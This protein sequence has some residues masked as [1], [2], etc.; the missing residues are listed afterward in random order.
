MLLL[1][2]WFTG[3]LSLSLFTFSGN[4]DDPRPPEEADVIAEMT[5]SQ[6][7]DT[8]VLDIDPTA[9]DLL[10][11]LFL[12]DLTPEEELNKLGGVASTMLPS[13]L[14]V[15]PEP[16]VTSNAST[17]LSSLAVVPQLPSPDPL[18][19]SNQSAVSSETFSPA[20][21]SDVQ[22][23]GGSALGD[24]VISTITSSASPLECTLTNG[25]N[26]PLDIPFLTE[27]TDLS[28][29][30]QDPTVLNTMLTSIAISTPSTIVNSTTSLSS[31]VLSD[32]SLSPCLGDSNTSVFVDVTNAHAHDLEIF[33]LATSNVPAFA[34]AEVENLDIDFSAF[35]VDTDTIT[36][37]PD[38]PDECLSITLTQAQH[39]SSPSSTAAED[40]LNQANISDSDD[41]FVESS[42]SP[43]PSEQLSEQDNSSTT[44]AS[45][46]RTASDM[47]LDTSADPPA[48]KKTK[49]TRR[50]KN[51]VASQISRAKRKA[52]NTSMFDRVG[53]LE[54]ENDILRIQEKELTAEIEKLKKLLVE[55][56]SQ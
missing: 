46:K 12:S 27:S 26:D 53:E 44:V 30:L 6:L 1:C 15:D 49:L 11:Q 34:T 17:P 7:L 38:S 24:D 45:R 42:P 40:D 20:P 4:F 52:K 55:R 22:S 16:S 10:M 3:D 39:Q 48:P 33:E 13:P 8:S 19:Q 9:N 2:T 25:S 31:N 32:C 50:Q 23:N 47:E 28:D 43:S 21:V 18:V 37:V 14:D 41:V 51:N 35:C 54:S 56:L 5:E 29:F 36:L